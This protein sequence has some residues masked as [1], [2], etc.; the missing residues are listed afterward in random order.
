[1]IRALVL[2]FAQLSDPA[3]R[4]VV[5]FGVV[6]AAAA[7][8]GLFVLVQWLLLGTPLVGLAWVDT[9]IDVL[10]GLLVLV[11][12]WILFPGVV[13]AV[14]SLVLDR[15]LDD[16]ERRH[17]PHLPPPRPP[18][19]LAE[20]ATA[21]RFLAVV[22]AVNVVALPLYLTLPGLNL[23]VYYTVNGYLLGREYFELVAIRRLGRR[24]AAD[25]RRAA[26]LRPFAAGAIIAFLSTVPLLNLFVPVVATA[27]MAHVYHTMNGRLRPAGRP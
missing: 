6:G 10:G 23:A 19:L 16:V 22:V 26:G 1:M 25:A 11:A 4:R 5:L 7:F 21:L 27:F 2:G 24:G 18:G 14:S 9:A 17:Y 13:A 15:V 12:A 8:I 3:S 20:V